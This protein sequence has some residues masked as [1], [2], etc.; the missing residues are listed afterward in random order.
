M[1]RPKNK[2]APA[3]NGVSVLVAYPDH[4]VPVAIGAALR[5][6]ALEAGSAGNGKLFR[7]Q[8]SSINRSRHSVPYRCD[9]GG[10]LGKTGADMQSLVPV[11]L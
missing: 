7:F 6:D 3:C 11:R 9:T 5:G 4:D 2:L 8:C 1:S 10:C